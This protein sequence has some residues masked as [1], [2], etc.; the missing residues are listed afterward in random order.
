MTAGSSTIL[1]PST[2]TRLTPAMAAQVDQLKTLDEVNPVGRNE[3]M[4][5]SP[6][7][8]GKTVM[9]GTFNPPFRWI[10]A[11]GENSLKSL[12]WAFKAGITSFKDLKELVFYAP[13][14]VVKGR[15]IGPA[16]AFNLMT[17]MI[18]YWF[19]P[20]QVDSWQTLVL[21]SFTEINTWALDLGLGLNTQY[22]K[23]DKPLST[24]D[25]INRK[26]MTRLVTGE[27][28]YKSAMGLVEGF[29]RNV[30]IE[31]AKHDKDLLVLCHEWQDY[32][33]D[34]DGNRVITAI[35]PAMIG[36]LRTKIVKDFDDVW[37][38]EKY[39][40]AG[41]LEIMA[42]MQGDSKVIAKSRWG[43]IMPRSVPADYRAII[44]EVKKFHEGPN[45][46]N[47]PIPAIRRPVPAGNAATKPAV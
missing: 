37:H 44:A 34:K 38:L 11:D 5:Y 31:C 28:D 36:Q 22:P 43:T 13:T 42:D 10:A 7:G 39:S 24:S 9:A 6:P 19:K 35:Q 32:S 25:A 12:R 23:P 33:E 26:A 40:R 46:P 8:G 29:L 3:V 17:D 21:D 16:Q 18:D 47:Q 45:Q 27:Q 15:Y 14:E 1:T 20:E 4:L 2:P 41:G 30:R